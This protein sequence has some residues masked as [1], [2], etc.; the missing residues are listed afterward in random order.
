MKIL[1]TGGLGFIGSNLI[2]YMLTKHKEIRIVNLDKISY[3]AN[4]SNLKDVE[5]DERYTFIK[6][7]ITNLDLMRTVIKKVDAVVNLAAESHVDRSIADPW[8][9]FRSNT[10]GALV[11]LEAVRSSGRK[12][13]IIHVSTDETYGDII[14]DSFKEE[15]RLKPSSPY[16]ASKAAADLFCLAYH[17]TYGLDVIVTR[18]TNN[19]GPYQFPEKFIPKAIIRAN[20]NMKV[21]IYGSG[22][23]VR[24]WIYVLDHCEALDLVLQDGEAGKIYNISSKNEL[25]NLE[26]VQ[27]ILKIM[28][29]PQELI[30]FVKDRPGHDLRYS[31]DSSKMMKFGWKPRHNFKESL[32]ENVNWYL[33]NEQWWR[34]IATEQ[35]L[36]PT[37]WKLKW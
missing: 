35:V 18:C 4:P 33:E 19:F 31:L 8:P 6:E 16:S 13:R 3:G 14:N 10:E 20:M 28:G 34:P 17:R 36:H 15:D 24:D 2:R 9:F 21:P 37:P 1:I 27:Q 30:E 25:S 7:D 23:N 11:L 12:N 26:V 32:S 22:E 5:A 29:K